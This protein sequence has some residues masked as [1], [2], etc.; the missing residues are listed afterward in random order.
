[1][2]YCS[3]AYLVLRELVADRAL[4]PSRSRD[5]P[6]EKAAPTS[7]LTAQERRRIFPTSWFR[8]LSVKESKL[9]NLSPSKIILM[10]GYQ[11]KRSR[12]PMLDIFL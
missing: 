12:C 6:Y 4:P 11:M 3:E 5:K 8:I 1:M 9:E 7:S 2:L 10:S